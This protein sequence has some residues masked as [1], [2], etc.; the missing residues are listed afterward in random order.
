[1][2]TQT[3]DIKYLSYF[4]KTFAAKHHTVM[5]DLIEKYNVSPNT[6]YRLM[7]GRYTKINVEH[8]LLIATITNTDPVELFTQ[9]P[10]VQAQR[11]TTRE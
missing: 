7:N 1:M 2:V 8:L 4:L 9:L 11:T 10:S 6:A 3:E 5:G